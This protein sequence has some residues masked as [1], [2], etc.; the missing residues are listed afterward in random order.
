M[1]TLLLTRLT[2]GSATEANPLWTADGHSLLF[3]SSRAGV[4][5]VFRQAADGAGQPEPITTTTMTMVT[6]TSIAPDGH[7]LA[8]TLGSADIGLVDLAGRGDPRQLISR[9]GGN[10]ATA[11][12]ISPDGRWIAYQSAESNRMEIYVRPFP[13][14]DAGRWQISSNGGT[15]PLWARNG[16]ELF[17]LSADSG[18]MAVAVETT[19]TFRP[20]N[21]TRLF[22]SGYYL[23]STGRT[24]DVSPDG[25][26]FLMIKELQPSSALAQ[27]TGIVV[28]NWFEELRQKLAIP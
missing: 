9:P 18:L 16:R 24:F 20:V 6:P 15:R 22:D 19:P 25:Q 14:I 8:V 11:G 23:G 4:P 28:L 26:R 17:Y 5:N 21:R 12:E 7:L 3:S 27:R 10:T 13:N 1:K 2:F